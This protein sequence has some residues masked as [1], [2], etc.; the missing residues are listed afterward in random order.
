MST[1]TKTAAIIINPISG[2]IDKAPVFE[3]IRKHFPATINYEI[4]VWEHPEQ[5]DDII[6]KIRTTNFDIVIAAGGDGTINQVAQAVLDTTSTLAIIPLGSGNGLAR[7]LKI[8]LDTKKAIE[9]IGNGKKN[10]ID[11]CTVNG[12]YFFC[13]SGIGF[14]A[15]IGKLFA[16]CKTRG[17]FTY[18]KLVFSNFINYKPLTYTLIV[19]EKTVNTKAFLITMANAGQYGNNVY[20]A[21]QADISDGL[22]D[23]VVVK[24]FKLWQS[25]LIA[26]KLFNKTLHLSKYVEIYTGKNIVVN[27]D[28]LGPVHFDG[29]PAE[30]GTVLRYQIQQCAI[31]V[32]VP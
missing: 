17:Y 2:G 27:R 15:L 23:I 11:V 5:K 12:N 20:I 32:I 8:P 10:K 14:D 13:T 3:L 30:M 28:A 29:E 18:L 31:E 7:H 9:L 25:I 22:I 16:A 26:K 19:D 4:I 1:P 21:P 6:K 24:P